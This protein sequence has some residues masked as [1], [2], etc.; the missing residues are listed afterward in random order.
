MTI[1]IAPLTTTVMGAVEDR[2]AGAASGVNNAVARVASLL[3]IALFGLFVSSTFNATFG[4]LVSTLHLTSLQ[5][6]ALEAQQGKLVGIGI[7][8]SI[9]GAARVAVHHAI[10]ESFLVGFR[11]AMLLGAGLALL[12]ALC[13][14]LFIQSPNEISSHSGE[15]RLDDNSDTLISTQHE[16]ENTVVELQ[17]H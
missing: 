9:Q 2:Y 17:G 13:S 6:H 4:S 5:M 10:A 7:P 11:V 3:T 8:E 16:Q 1:T 15:L 14:L 12:S